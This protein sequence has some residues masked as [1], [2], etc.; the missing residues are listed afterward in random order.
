M[1]RIVV[2]KPDGKNLFGRVKHAGED[3]IKM[4]YLDSFTCFS[5]HFIH[6]FINLRAHLCITRVRGGAVG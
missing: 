5:L 3:N 1:Y 6:L 2:G 4:F